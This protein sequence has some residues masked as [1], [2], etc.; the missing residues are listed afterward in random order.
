M[1]RHFERTQVY[2]LGQRIQSL[3]QTHPDRVVEIETILSYFDEELSRVEF[4]DSRLGEIIDRYNSIA[5]DL[6][7]KR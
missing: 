1:N 3:T 4:G 7:G 2:E 6:G 5:R